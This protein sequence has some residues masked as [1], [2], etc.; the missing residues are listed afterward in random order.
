MK[1]AYVLSTFPAISETFIQRE[2]QGMRARG[3]EVEVFAIKR[4]LHAATTTPFADPEVLKRCSYSRPDNV[5]RDSANN[6]VALLLHPF[7]YWSVARIYLEETW[8][9][10]PPIAFRVLYHCFCGVGLVSTLRRHRITHIHGHFAGA[11][12]ALAASL[13]SG[14]P[15]SWTAQASNDI[16]VK[17]ILLRAKMHFC[18]FVV[19]ISNYNKRYLQSLCPVPADKIHVIPNGVYLSEDRSNSLQTTQQRA[20][21]RIVSAGR[22]I[23]VKGFHTLIEACDIVKQRGHRI[24]CRILGGGPEEA[25]LRSLISE[26]HLDDVVC[27]TGFRPLAD[28]YTELRA[29]DVFV[30]LSEIGESGH[31]DGLPTVL[32]E[33]MLMSLPVVSTYI[34][35][36]PE[37]VLEGET[38]LL[39]PERNPGRVADALERLITNPELRTTF[40]H[41]GRGRLEKT[42]NADTNLDELLKVM[43]M[44][45]DQERNCIAPPPTISAHAGRAQAKRGRSDA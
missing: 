44:S 28:I 17:P 40:G 32:L 6:L 20:V 26:R 1:I 8:R 43:T 29:A 24:E 21:F 3:C 16:Y 42:F 27:L 4:P 30:L 33:A 36:I 31:R 18:R 35:G 7:R 19:T 11:E 13:Y 25:A 45:C 39:V 15:F 14:I 12:I 37:I 10:A 2:I 22:L 23:D 9:V 5:W 34:S 41:A 38:G